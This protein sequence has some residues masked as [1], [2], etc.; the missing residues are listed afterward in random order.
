MMLVNPTL[1]ILTVSVF[2]DPLEPIV[3]CSQGKYMTRKKFKGLIGWGEVQINQSQHTSDIAAKLTSLPEKF[4]VHSAVPL[5]I[6]L[7][8]AF[9]SCSQ[10]SHDWWHLRKM[11]TPFFPP[12]LT[13]ILDTHQ[14]LTELCGPSR[15]C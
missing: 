11:P 1:Q 4:F 13:C 8:S 3:L 15:N 2:S 7:F 14:T 12:A 5:V 6:V 9:P 10:Y